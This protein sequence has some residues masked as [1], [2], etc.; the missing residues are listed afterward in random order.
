MF[1]ML[2]VPLWEVRTFV[3]MRKV[4]PNHG[5]SHQPRDGSSQKCPDVWGAHSSWNSK[6][7]STVTEMYVSARDQKCVLKVH[8]GTIVLNGKSVEY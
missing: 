3:F 5:L 6:K 8:F 4:V 2:H 7:K 1:K